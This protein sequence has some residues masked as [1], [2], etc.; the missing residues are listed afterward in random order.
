[1]KKSVIIFSAVLITLSLAAFNVI[2]W[3]NSKTGQ[4]ATLENTNIGISTPAKEKIT[5]RFFP[6][7]IYDVGPRFGPIKKSDLNKVRSFDELI[8][9][10]DAQRIV[11][12]NSVSV[13]VVV[14]D[15]ESSRR[16]NGNS[17]TLNTAQL[18]FIQTLEYST[19]LMVR[20]DV[21]QRNK[22]TGQLEDSS[23]TPYLTVVPETQADYVNGKD[24]LKNY[25]KENSKEVR[26]QSNVDPERLQPAKLY[27]TVTKN[28]NIENARLDRS[29]NY[30]FVDETML[31][32]IRKTTGKWT[33]AE[34]QDGKKVD[35]ELVV[36]F[37]LLG[38]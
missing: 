28:G 22:E 1:M 11:D 13:I 27:F 21:E 29:S 33:P 26:E 6:D 23:W 34:D 20:A 19:N 8:D 15:E 3:N 4:M 14:N 31:D 35:Q 7:F 30:P 25:L 12:Y 5:K 18:K 32:L 2:D 38:C 9:V 37:G 16:E 24:A 17:P 36:S 10:D